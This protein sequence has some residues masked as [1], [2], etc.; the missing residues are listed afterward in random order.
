MPQINRIP[1]L[2]LVLL[3]GFFLL[4]GC[5]SSSNSPSAIDPVKP[6]HP[7]N[8]LPAGHVAAAESDLTSCSQCHGSDFSGGISTVSCTQCHLGDFQTIHPLDWDNLVAIKHAGYVNSNGNSAC[9]NINCHG[10]TLTGVAGSGPSCSSCHLGGKGSVHPQDWG[11]LAYSKHPP[12]VAQNGTTAC[13][14]IVCH[15]QNLTGVPDSGP[16]CTSCHLGGLNSVHPQD[17]GAL[18]YVRHRVYVVSNGTASCSNMVCHG[19][20]LTGVA[21]SGPSCSSCHLGGSG[22]VHPTDWANNFLQHA[23]Y[24][25]S[26]GAGSCRNA[27]CHGADLRGVSASGLSCF[28]CHQFAIP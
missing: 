5:G 27:V 7:D 25:N 10:A 21:G 19:A 16:S 6:G 8:W 28:L 18:T 4:L 22:S 12:Y 15:G 20:N 17:W 2:G 23:T 11:T 3:I 1:A 24:V 14:N 9:S 26:F 13:S